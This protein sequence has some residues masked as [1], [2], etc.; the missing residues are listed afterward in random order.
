MCVLM[1]NIIIKGWALWC[2]VAIP[3]L[4][5][6]R[7]ENCEFEDRVGCIARHYPPIKIQQNLTGRSSEYKL[8]LKISR[9]PST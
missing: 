5:R 4:R 8:D 7:Q 2:T 3:V 9:N 1:F 6:L